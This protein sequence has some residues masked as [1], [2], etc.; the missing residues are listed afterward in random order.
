MVIVLSPDL[1]IRCP[2]VV[3][4]K[5]KWLI[6]PFFLDAVN[7][8]RFAEPDTDDRKSHNV[9]P[10]LVRFLSEYGYADPVPDTETWNSDLSKPASIY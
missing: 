6:E 7:G 8:C 5:I 9:F 4:I 1:A 2:Y 10:Q 3:C